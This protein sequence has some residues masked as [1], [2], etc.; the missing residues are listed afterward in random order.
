MAAAD[1][2]EYDL[3]HHEVAAR[4]AEL[5]QR[6]TAGRRRLIEQLATFARPVTIPELV[7]G[8]EGLALSSAYRNLAV[9]EAVG[10]V[11]RVHSGAEHA[12]YELA[13]EVTGGH[14]HH[15]IC[16]AC[17]RVE[18]FRV[19]AAVEEGIDRLLGRVVSEHGFV[20]SSHRLD[21]LGRCEA[22]HRE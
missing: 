12:L 9:L 18:D 5:E 15:L 19:S 8:A 1:P 4:L 21:L 2:R 13:E 6:Y 16:E 14:H 10:V 3:L 22:C 17:G 11:T 7:D 20:V